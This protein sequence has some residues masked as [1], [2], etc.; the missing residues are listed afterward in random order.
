MLN[1]FK[2]LSRSRKSQGETKKNV[3]PKKEQAQNKYGM[4]EEGTFPSL[5]YRL[6]ITEEGKKISPWHDISTWVDKGKGIV[7]AVIE[8][9]KKTTPKMEVATKEETNPILQDTK[10]GKLRD[11]AVQIEWNYGMIPQTWEDPNVEHPE[12]KAMGDNDPLDVVEIGHASVPRGTV[13]Q[14]KALGILAM[15]DDGELDWKV[16]ALNTADPKADS[17]NSLADV[18]KVFPGVIDKVREWFRTY[19]VPTGKPENKFGLDEKCMDEVYTRQVIDETH[20]HWEEL[21]AGNSNKGDV[22]IG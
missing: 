5:E 10:K 6:F 14:A 22:W 20:H 11:Y 21:K 3:N 18:E 12:V 2:R 16:I 4:I 15:I 1:P 9:P 7:N 13:I 17:V 8:I 19:K